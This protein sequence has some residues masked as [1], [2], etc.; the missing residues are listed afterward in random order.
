MASRIW[1]VTHR[2]KLTRNANTNIDMIR[3]QASYED[4]DTNLAHNNKRAQRPQPRLAT[5]APR[6]AHRAT[7]KSFKPGSRH[8]KF[9]K[10]SERCTLTWKGSSTCFSSH[11]RRKH[12]KHYQN[13]NGT[14][15]CCGIQ[16]DGSTA[17]D[18]IL[19]HI[20]EHDMEE[21]S[22]LSTPQNI[23]TS[24]HPLQLPAV[25][26]LPTPPSANGGLQIVLDPQMTLPYAS[27][28]HLDFQTSGTDYISDEKISSV[29][30]H[31]DPPGAT[32]DDRTINQQ[33]TEDLPQDLVFISNSFPNSQTMSD[34]SWEYM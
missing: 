12:L 9:C 17:E 6:H 3:G 24:S 30:I 7:G 4:Q 19:D 32:T 21:V 27:G 18:D 10:K 11:F 5:S 13:R 1:S 28:F 33:I 29:G 34:Y 31:D 26:A 25:I 2:M 14:Y 22:L 23:P 20:W 8:S 15:N 16:F